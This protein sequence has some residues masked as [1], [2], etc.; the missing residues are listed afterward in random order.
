MWIGEGGS[1]QRLALIRP[2]ATDAIN[3]DFS[4][5]SFAVLTIIHSGVVLDT[6]VA[7]IEPLY[8]RIV[9]PARTAVREH[10]DVLAAFC[11]FHFNLSKVTAEKARLV[12]QGRLL[13]VRRR[14]NSILS[15]WVPR[16]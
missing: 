9:K 11:S 5:H 10:S 15:W 4:H 1:L 7:I 13:P 14:D 8:L 3:L 12:D 16:S 2:T 6:Q